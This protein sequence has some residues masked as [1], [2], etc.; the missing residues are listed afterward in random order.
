MFV[1]IGGT[2]GYR[3]LNSVSG[4]PEEAEVIASAVLIFMLFEA[5]FILVFVC[6]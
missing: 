6:S 4:N 2:V 3:V 1:G 5:V